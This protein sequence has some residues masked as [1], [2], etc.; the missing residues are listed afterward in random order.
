[1]LGHHLPVDAHGPRGRTLEVDQRAREGRLA[2]ARLAH[3]SEHLAARDRR[4][5]HR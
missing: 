2:R 4:G 1:M 5:R 3:E